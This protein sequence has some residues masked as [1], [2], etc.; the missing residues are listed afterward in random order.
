MAYKAGK[1]ERGGRRKMVRLHR[2]WVTQTK[3]NAC[4]LHFFLKML[5]LKAQF[6]LLC[7]LPHFEASSSLPFASI[8]W[9]TLRSFK[10]TSLMSDS[11]GAEKDNNGCKIKDSGR[12]SLELT[13]LE[14]GFWLP[15]PPH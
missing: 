7:L 8:G 9:L 2:S 3:Q 6:V 14:W 11:D 4:K 12:S 5:Y 15:Q 1:G 13:Y 10:I